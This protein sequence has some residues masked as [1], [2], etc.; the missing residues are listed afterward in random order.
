MCASKDVDNGAGL[1]RLKLYNN[2]KLFRTRPLTYA[3]FLFC[4]QDALPSLFLFQIAL[5]F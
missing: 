3:F 4:L 2:D 5:M 1:N